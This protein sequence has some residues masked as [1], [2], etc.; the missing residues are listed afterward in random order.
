MVRTRQST[1]ELCLPF[2][3]FKAADFGQ[4]CQYLGLAPAGVK[5]VGMS[6]DRTPRRRRRGS[7]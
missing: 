1:G 3:D 5:V 7:R 2:L 6:Q 4:L